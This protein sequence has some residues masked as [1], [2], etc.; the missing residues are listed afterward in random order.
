MQSQPGNID[1]LS[2]TF[3]EIEEIIGGSLP[4]SAYNHRNWWDNDPESRPQSSNWLEA[5]WRAGY[6]NIV[7]KNISFVRI[8]EREKAYI[9]F[10]SALLHQLREAG[11][12]PVGDPS[13]G[14][15]SWIIVVQDA[16]N[17]LFGYSFGRGKRFRVELYIDTGKQDTTKQILDALHERKEKI[18]SEIGPLSWER[19][20]NKRA[21][22]IAIYHPGHINDPEKKMVS[23]RKWAVD[24]MGN[25]YNSLAPHLEEITSEVL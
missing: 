7:G 13:P 19:L 2:L 6:R 9:D 18:E 21:S 22:R 12:V 11:K 15:T 3:S 10:Y 4:P 25:F 23:L 14:G 17:T 20:D 16:Q 8:K 24:T 5:G 1:Q